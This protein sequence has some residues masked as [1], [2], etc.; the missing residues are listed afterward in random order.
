MKRNTPCPCSKSFTS[1]IYAQYIP[2]TAPTVQTQQQ[3]QWNWKNAQWRA[4]APSG[5]VLHCA[6]LLQTSNKRSPLSG[7]AH[8]PQE[9]KHRRE[10]YAVLHPRS[11]NSPVENPQT[12]P[13]PVPFQGKVPGPTWMWRPSTHIL[14]SHNAGATTT[15]QSNNKGFKSPLINMYLLALC[16]C[17]RMWYLFLPSLNFF[18]YWTSLCGQDYSCIEQD[19]CLCSFS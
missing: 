12:T 8:R 5:L 11:C 3:Q 18:P 13:K 10:E 4:E 6:Y 9:T 2:L 16:Y 1:A 17:S 14:T 19:Y 15:S 7:G